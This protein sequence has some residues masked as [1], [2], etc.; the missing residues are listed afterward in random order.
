MTKWVLAA[1]SILLNCALAYLLYFKKGPDPQ[2]V[3]Q[4]RQV[5]RTVTQAGKV[6]TKTQEVVKT[7]TASPKPSTKYKLGIQ[8]DVSKLKPNIDLINAS[9][10]LYKPVWLDAGYSPTKN[11]F[12]LGISIEF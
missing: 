11:E 3:E 2:I 1:T 5:T 9:Y 4:V 12:L 7:V 10:R 6:V 8:T